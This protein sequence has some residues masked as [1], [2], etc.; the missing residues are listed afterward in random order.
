MSRP[1]LHI[2]PKSPRALFA[3]GKLEPKKETEHERLK[4]DYE[5]KARLHDAFGG[6]GARVE[7]ERAA[8]KLRSYEGRL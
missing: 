8:F 5:E 3:G 7:M 6:D 4:R 1:A 2:V